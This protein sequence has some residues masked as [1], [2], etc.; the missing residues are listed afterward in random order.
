MQS[1]GLI[2]ALLLVG[3]THVVFPQDKGENNGQS[4]ALTVQKL[5]KGFK[6]A[7]PLRVWALGEPS[8]E[9]LGNGSILRQ[10]LITRFPH[11]PKIELKTKTV[12]DASWKVLNQWITMNVLHDHPDLVILYAT[13]KPNELDSLLTKIR[14]HS[15]ADILVPSI[16]WRMIDGGNWGKIEN[17]VDQDIDVL[18]ETC[19]RH[20]AE[21][22]ENRKIWGEHLREK[23]QTIDKLL[24]DSESINANGANL[25]RENILAHLRKPVKNFNYKP[26]TRERRVNV[27]FKFEPGE[28]FDLPFTGN[29]IELV[30]IHSPE[31][32]NAQIIING[33][34]VS[35][36]SFSGEN[37]KVFR[38]GIVTNLTNKR[39]FLRIV[40]EEGKAALDIQALE[41]YE[42]PFKPTEP[43]VEP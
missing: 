34:P 43:N 4:L 26:R 2:S 3:C 18:R 16:H 33:K 36:I 12:K 11:C 30:G 5:Q 35:R 14:T 38:A 20:G 29:R 37:G 41:I 9:S 39:H 24:K 6:P 28:A 1:K 42:P 7:R 27:F 22:V 32:G 25:L 15:T 40:P 17:A 13:G 23:K 21:F 8:I 19:R 10:N 31:G